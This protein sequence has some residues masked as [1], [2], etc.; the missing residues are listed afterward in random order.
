MCS[1]LVQTL[2]GHT[3]QAGDSLPRAGLCCRRNEGGGEGSVKLL[4]KG[5][6]GKY[7]MPEGL[8]SALPPCKSSHGQHR[9]EWVWLFQQNFIH[10]TGWI[11]PAAQDGVDNLGPSKPPAWGWGGEHSRRHEGETNLYSVS[12]H[13]WGSLY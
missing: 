7:C 6:G 4:S 11:W 12:H 8:C 2:D 1:A 3:E 9:N 10:K 5:L 13:I